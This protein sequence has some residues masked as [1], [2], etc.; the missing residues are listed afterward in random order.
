MVKSETEISFPFTRNGRSFNAAGVGEVPCGRKAPEGV[1]ILVVLDIGAAILT[2]G[3]ILSARG[4][5]EVAVGS[6]ETGVGARNLFHLVKLSRHLRC[7]FTIF[8]R[9]Q[10]SLLTMLIVI[11]IRIQTPAS[12]DFMVRFRIIS[13]YVSVTRQSSS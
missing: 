9:Q 11:S 4:H 12:D 6:R 1:V 5:L 2:L 7:F 10:S 3:W 13:F 8:S